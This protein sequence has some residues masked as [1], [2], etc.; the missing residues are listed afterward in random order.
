[1][2]SKLIYI[3]SIVA[4]VAVIIII[5][6]C[7]EENIDL[8][9]LGETE[10]AFFTNQDAFERGIRGTYAKLT[11]FYWFNANNPNH[12]VWLLPGDDL[13][14]DGDFATEKFTSL[15]PSHGRI[16]YIWDKTYELISRSN[17]ILEKIETVGEESYD[18][19]ELM[20]Y[21]TGEALFLRSW[22][23]Y[24]LFVFWEK[25]PLVTERIQGVG[26]NTKKPESEGTELLDQAIA[27]LTQ[28]AELLPSSWKD[29]FAG[30]VTKDGAN[31]LLGR[32][33]M[34]RAAYGGGNADYLAALTAFNK[35]S[36]RELAPKFSDN[37]DAT[38]ENNIE[39]LFEFQASNAPQFE[40][41]WLAACRT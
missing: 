26:E 6:A 34:V 16:S 10:T 23:N 18:N 20:D 4:F 8:P 27:D 5:S 29:E 28:A 31:A 21:N 15:Q 13:T 30:R 40:N 32:V 2:K 9:P 37:F 24:F 41:I 22:G 17:I 1:M 39:S 12:E 36:T 33:L 35:I 19:P 7:N 38:K 11:D 14:T 25:A 3:T